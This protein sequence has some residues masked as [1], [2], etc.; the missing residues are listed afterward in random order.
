MRNKTSGFNSF[1]TKV[2]ERNDIPFED[3]LFGTIITL[4]SLSNI[5][6]FQNSKR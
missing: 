5:C 4:E 3:F 6:S 1:K 2:L